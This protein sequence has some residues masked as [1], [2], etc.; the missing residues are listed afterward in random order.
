MK[1][2]NKA[3]I[4]GFLAAVGFISATVGLWDRFF[5]PIPDNEILL[6]PKSTSDITVSNSKIETNYLK[7]NNLLIDGVKLEI[8]EGGVL[9]ANKITMKNGGEIFGSNIYVVSTIIDNG[10]INASYSKGMNGG[11]IFVVSA[12]INGTEITSNGKN[13]LHGKNGANGRSGAAGANG[14][15]GSCKGFGGWRSAHAGGSGGN[16]SNGTKGENGQDGGNAGNITI[17]TSYALT[18]AP[19]SNGGS[20]GKEGKGGSP[21]LGGKGGRGGRGCTGLGGSQSTQPSGA[22]GND[23]VAGIDGQDGK[24]GNRKTPTVKLVNF[25]DIKKA[26]DAYGNDKVKFISALRNIRP[27]NNANK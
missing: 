20:A 4:G 16:A 25:I 2:K 10:K 26:V 15:N 3:I 11:N 19:E 14:R 8:E 17:L 5:P 13:G 7:A 12:Q 21:G 24:L 23:G 18:T 6:L 27:R 1:F 22:D 9:L